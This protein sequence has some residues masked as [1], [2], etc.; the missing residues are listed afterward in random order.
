MD[1]KPR[2]FGYARVS[3]RHQNEDRQLQALEEVPIPP[4][5]IYVDKQSGKDFE[6]DQYQIL[7]EKLRTVYQEY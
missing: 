4:Q 5:N 3:T 1:N 7:L 2:L 6:R